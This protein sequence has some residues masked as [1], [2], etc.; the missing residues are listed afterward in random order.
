MVVGVVVVG[1]MIK[2]VCEWWVIA[3]INILFWYQAHRSRGC[4][5]MPNRGGGRGWG[6]CK[7]REGGREEWMEREGGREGGGSGGR[8]GEG[9]TSVCNK[10]V[11]V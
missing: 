3:S 10:W 5:S 11:I 2:G 6:V 9:G 4:L 7:G 1:V 8:G